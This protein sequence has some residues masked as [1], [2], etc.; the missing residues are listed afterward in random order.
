MNDK[1]VTGEAHRANSVELKLNALLNLI[2]KLFAPAPLRA[3]PN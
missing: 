2:R 3:S 1:E